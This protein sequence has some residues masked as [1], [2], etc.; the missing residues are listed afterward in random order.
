MGIEV[1]KE[2]SGI[3]EIV[4]GGNKRNLIGVTLTN[5]LGGE[6]ES[7]GLRT[8]CKGTHCECELTW[9]KSLEK[10]EKRGM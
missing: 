4:R 3:A 7:A 5:G 9:D 6:K 1:R 2:R 10:E 8:V